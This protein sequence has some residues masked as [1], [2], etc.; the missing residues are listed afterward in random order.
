MVELLPTL[1]YPRNPTVNLGP[2]SIE[3]KDLGQVIDQ[4]L[5]KVLGKFWGRGVNA[6][7]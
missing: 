2:D 6:F 7:K 5:G 1:G 4:V 3:I